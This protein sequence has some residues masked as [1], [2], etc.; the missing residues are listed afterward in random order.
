MR[1]FIE[2]AGCMGTGIRCKTNFDQ[3]RVDHRT[4][5]ILVAGPPAGYSTG[6]EP[7]GTGCP[8]AER[9][10]QA[11][12]QVREATTVDAIT[13]SLDHGFTLTA[14]CRGKTTTES[15]LTVIGAHGRR[16]GIDRVLGRS[17]FSQRHPF[18]A[19][20][21]HF[22]GPPIPG[23][24]RLHTFPGGYCG[25]SEIEGD[26]Q[27]VCLLV[28]EDIFQHARQKNGPDAFIAWMQT[29]NPAIQSWLG[30]AE[31]I[32]E[33]WI[34]IAQVPFLSKPVVDGDVVMA[35]D[36]AG[37]IPPLAGNGIS[38]ALEGG[39]LAANY[40]TTFLSRQIS[41]ADL[42]RMYASAWKQKFGTRLKLGLALQ[43]VMLRPQSVRFALRAMNLFPWLGQYLVEHTRAVGKNEG[44]NQFREKNI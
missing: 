36:A 38:M 41:A 44:G 7:E 17:F 12:V 31:R 33:R 1:W 32:H 39:A 24:I 6:F 25:M 21:A 29:Q 15:A 27:V 35:G 20:K 2:R 13:G 10:Q 3:Q 28:R 18:V 5:W 11:G 26:A 14:R 16:A 30:Q 42:R 34:A 43:P 22:H 9:A 4:R 37:L 23:Q 8:L 19:L 40:I